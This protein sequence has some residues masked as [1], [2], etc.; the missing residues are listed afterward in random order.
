MLFNSFIFLLFFPAVCL[1]YYAIKGNKW[2]NLFLLAASYFFYACWIPLYA[3]LLAGVTL[4]AYWGARR[5]SVAKEKKHHAKLSLTIV[6]LILFLPLLFF[7]YY[8]FINNT[9]WSI[10]SLIGISRIVPGMDILLPVG[11]SFYTFQAVGY[12]VDVYRGSLKPEKNLATFA[13][14]LSFFPQLVAGP[15]ERA[16][17]LLPQFYHRHTFDYG[18]AV[19]GMRLMLWGY[20]IKL[21]VADRLGV[22]V[23]AVYSNPASQ[24]GTSL[25]VATLFF[26]FQI[27]GDFGG[28]SLIAVGTA[29]ILGF[30]IIQNFNRPYLSTSIKEFWR[31]WHISLSAWLRDYVY[32]PLGGNR[33]PYPRHLFNLF[34]TFLVCG[35]WHGA[36]WCYV[37]W[38]ALHG[39]YI[40]IESILSKLFHIPIKEPKKWWI[41]T[42][43]IALVF[44]LTSVAW[45]FFR[46][47]SLTG[48]VTILKAIFT[49]QSL[50]GFYHG[51]RWDTLF[52]LAMLL[53]LCGKEVMQ[54]YGSA[55][56][57]NRHR[58]VRWSSYY[59]LVALII[60][61]GLNTVESFIYFQF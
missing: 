19:S 36:S 13:L 50:T 58:A 8:N 35:L 26:A 61:F 47:R 12:C 59:A 24:N 41:K 14:F 53:I 48:A 54:E 60:I 1:I 31:R 51:N 34:I 18:L 32:I 39:L 40:T 46:A 23:D 30:N 55:T 49:R 42:L 29:R 9:L 43:K 16:G 17:H 22:Y 57:W 20:F 6:L 33:V 7:K 28:Y 11:I 3:L 52:T 10:A 2:R 21:C 45:V 27:Y 5:L 38:G 37:A 4:A 25:M 56:W 44:G 15:I